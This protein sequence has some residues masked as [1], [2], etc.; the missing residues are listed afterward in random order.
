MRKL[1]EQYTEKSC[2][3]DAMPPGTAVEMALK[4]QYTPVVDNMLLLGFST[5]TAKLAEARSR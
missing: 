2:S 3:F 5:L 4:V 1:P